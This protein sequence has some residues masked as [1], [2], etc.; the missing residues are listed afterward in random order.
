MKHLAFSHDA[1]VPECVAFGKSIRLDLSHFDDGWDVL[2]RTSSLLT[3]R[4]TRLPC[5]A[6]LLLRT[7]LGL[8]RHRGAVDRQ[9][10]GLDP[11]A[12]LLADRQDLLGALA[13]EPSVQR[14]DLLAESLDELAVLDDLR[15]KL[16]IFTAQMRHQ[17][18]R[19]RFERCL[20]IVDVV[21]RHRQP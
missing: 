7:R 6:S 21:S 17:Q 15:T 20:Q 8:F 19:R 5:L 14:F 18:A 1:E 12:K 4:L 2:A 11:L 3:R 13:K 9:L 16:G 10:T